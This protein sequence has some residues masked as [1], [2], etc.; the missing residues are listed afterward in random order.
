M[1]YIIIRSWYPPSKVDAVVKRY[2]EV[3]KK[4]PPDEFLAK[5]VVQS[6]SFATK[7]GIEAITVLE[8]VNEKLTDALI[9]SMAALAE[10]RDIEGYNYE[11]KPWATVEESLSSIGMG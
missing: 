5:T 3:M 8:A 9:R 7:D 11:I 6:A 1:P 10:F 2:I 4:Y